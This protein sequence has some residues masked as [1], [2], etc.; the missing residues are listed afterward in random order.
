MSETLVDRSPEGSAFEIRLTRVLRATLM[1][2]VIVWSITFA[3]PPVGA[4]AT[5]LG[6]ATLLTL[7]LAAPLRWAHQAKRLTR[8]FAY[9]TALAIVSAIAISHIAEQRVSVG[10]A[11]AMIFALGPVPA[12]AALLIDFIWKDEDGEGL[13]WI[14]YL[15][16]RGWIRALIVVAQFAWLGS[17]D[18]LT[19]GDLPLL[20]AICAT[21]IGRPFLGV[22]LLLGA[23]PF[24][25]FTTAYLAATVLTL[26]VVVA[27]LPPRP[28]ARKFD[29]PTSSRAWSNPRHR[30]HL[31]SVDRMLSR[32]DWRS[33]EKATR[34][35][36]TEPAHR[37][38]DLLL[39][40]AVALS[41]LSRPQEAADAAREALNGGL[42]A[43]EATSR[44]IIGEA[45][46]ALDQQAEAERELLLAMELL[47]E[48]AP[49]QARVSLALAEVYI[50]LN[51]P[52]RS[53]TL[54]TTAQ[55][56]LTGQGRFVE[57]MRAIRI[58]FQSG[59]ALDDEALI[60]R[61][62]DSE[63][64]AIL[65]TRWSRSYLEKQGPPRN[66]E[67]ALFS[68]SAPMFVE[69][70]FLNALKSKT[71][72]RAASP[73]SNEYAEAMGEIEMY[74]EL[75]GMV[76]Y[77]VERAELEVFLATAHRSRGN[78]VEG[79]ALATNALIDLD[80]VRHSIRT[81]R[82]RAVWAARFRA[83]LE[84]A[85]EFAHET[86][87]SLRVAE[88]I[89]LARVQAVPIV[90]TSSEIEFGL[91]QAPTV[92]VRGQASVVRYGSTRPPADL[93]TAA[94]L[95]AGPEAWWLSYWATSTDL[96]WSLLPSDNRTLHGRVSIEAG[97][98]LAA[99]LS[100]LRSWLPMAVDGESGV[101]FDYRINASP[102]LSSP[103][104][105]REMSV[106]LGELLLP[107]VL[108]F[109]LQRRAQANMEA[110]AL[111]ISPA[112]E[113][114]FVPWSLLAVLT[115]EGDLRLVECTNW[116]LAPSAS[117][118][119][120]TGDREPLAGPFP[121]RLAVLDPTDTPKAPD[122]PFARSISTL[123]TADVDILGGRHWTTNIATKPSLFEALSACPAKA[124]VL[125]GCH[126]VTSAE[127]QT[128]LGALVLAGTDNVATELLTAMEIVRGSS[129]ATF[130][131]Q[132]CLQAC[133]TTDLAAAT[134]GEWLGLA[135]A[136]LAAGARTVLTTS[137][138][139]VD[140]E[141][142]SNSTEDRLLASIARGDDLT[143]SVRRE[144]L[145]G[146]A[147]WREL[148]DGATV[149]VV[150]APL[151]WSAYA[152]C[153]GGRSQLP[154]TGER[155]ELAISERLIRELC[156]AARFAGPLRRRTIT[157]AHLCG[158]YLSNQ[159]DVL[160]VSL[161]RSTAMAFALRAAA[162]VLSR[163]SSLSAKPLRPSDELV[164][165]ALHAA[166]IARFAG[167]PLEPEHLV[168]AAMDDRTSAANR[169]LRLVRLS[170][171]VAMR[172]QVESNLREVT[173]AR[174][175]ADGKVNDEFRAFADSVTDLLFVPRSSSPRPSREAQR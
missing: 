70:N 26:L 69:V 60:K 46:H 142:Q 59:L 63:T 66:E 143:T 169:L 80:A 94:A 30:F 101:A 21:A 19:R 67:T 99:L 7:R 44:R 15:S 81:Q 50:D 5:G 119:S 84:L 9:L 95:A 33:A 3:A 34:D 24:T 87:N 103:S 134:S 159:T 107:E 18:Q 152:I 91:A 172:Q 117:L 165:L 54:A 114:G 131:A 1:A 125:F 37:S 133:D 62:V 56:L 175:S 90:G 139:L 157:S 86:H 108:R 151:V 35:R 11:L 47:E 53:L 57:R 78:P 100:E 51:K 170:R 6:I 118:L 25:G 22:G 97:S 40:R 121:L 2:F 8:A 111:A 74:A 128:S 68:A 155:P 150:D 72:M 137:F 136:L 39:R 115:D 116:T 113:I 147:A 85:L 20:P 163:R 23:L 98:E 124:T 162:S 164:N 122:L 58:R 61:I 16:L 109:E 36:P 174:G 88:L 48:H 127:G 79:L 49:H 105:E 138:P 73:D 160:V 153:S 123:L 28:P 166:D 102:L 110:L 129:Y 38:T 42:A 149:N 45:L 106:R 144:Q 77:P 145:R 75:F 71:V 132:V 43:V 76:G 13:G 82:G 29:L 83:A 92:R 41:E 156:D 112:P 148:A 55:R 31:Y 146:L 65:S 158:S 4:F 14:L 168:L 126:A 93:E 52:D 96:Y 104:A 135:P 173:H 120:A 141:L 32:S 140:H 171:S 161:F 154:N 10:W 89:E 64:V 27:H 167:T 17:R 12:L 130:P